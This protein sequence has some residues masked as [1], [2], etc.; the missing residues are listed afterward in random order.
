MRHSHKSTLPNLSALMTAAGLTAAVCANSAL[1]ADPLQEA[2]E[3]KLSEPPVKTL[4]AEASKTPLSSLSSPEKTVPKP[5][6]AEELRA[7]LSDT[8]PLANPPT[9]KPQNAVV[10]FNRVGGD[11]NEATHLALEAARGKTA[12][13]QTPDGQA[14]DAES[15]LKWWLIGGLGCVFVV[16]AASLVRPSRPS[17]DRRSF[18]GGGG[19]GGDGMFGDIIEAV[20]NAIDAI[21]DVGG[22]FGDGGG[23]GGG[24]GDISSQPK[25]SRRSGIFMTGP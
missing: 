25:M 12:P 3:A 16:V 7:L 19:G 8:P 17:R 24:G 23:D 5:I 15:Y 13:K 14:Q 1:A 22:G 2:L 6:T 9:P 18:S 21:G 4:K 11:E 20:G 10:V